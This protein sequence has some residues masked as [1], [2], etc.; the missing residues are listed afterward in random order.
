MKT[1]HTIT[2]KL[3]QAQRQRSCVFAAND[4]ERKALR[5]RTLAGEL[6][7]PH[8]GM[9][10]DARYWD[11]LNGSEKALHI[12]RTL[13][14]RHP[15]WVF[16]GPTAAAIHGFDHQWSIHQAVYI[17]VTSNSGRCAGSVRRI[18][19]PSLVAATVQGLRVTPAARTLVDCALMLSFATTLPIFDSA[20]RKE[21]CTASDIRSICASLHRGTDAVERLLT[22]ADPMSE[23]GG[24]SLAR[25]V[26]IEAG[27]EVPQ[28]QRVF[29]DPRNPREWYRVDF[30]WAFPGGYTVV[31]EYDGMAKYVDPTMTG[32]RTIQAV[33]NQQ[34]ERER[35]LYAWGVSKIVRIGYDD[36]VRRQPL[37]DKLDD[38][39]IPR[40]V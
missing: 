15:T 14:E 21:C 19:M 37:I 25:A 33:V 4:A 40:A 18:F 1:H 6:T 20:L 10:A 35:K 16:A 13:Q 11:T 23:N 5:R 9:F 38:A 2:D 32:R 24:E 17:A 39:G 3:A 31:A 12:A 29:V 8:P 28:L 34:S 36:V 26:I 27:F 7:S 22:Y 30:V